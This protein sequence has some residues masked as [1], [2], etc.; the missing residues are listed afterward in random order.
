MLIWFLPSSLQN[1]SSQ[2]AQWKKKKKKRPMISLSSSCSDCFWGWWVRGWGCAAEHSI[3]DLRIDRDQSRA[4]LGFLFP[5]F[6][7][8]NF[9]LLCHFACIMQTPTFFN[10]SPQRSPLFSSMLLGMEFSTIPSKV[11]LLGQTWATF[12]PYGLPLPLGRTP[13]V[14]HWSWAGD[15]LFPE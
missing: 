3:P 11:S 9:R 5:W 6:S 8:L 15:S 10:C 12:L 1:G 13:P 14:L 4:L 2:S 7:L